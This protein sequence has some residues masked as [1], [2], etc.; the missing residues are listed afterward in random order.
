[1]SSLN[2]GEFGRVCQKEELPE[3]RVTK[4]FWTYSSQ[5]KSQNRCLQWYSFL[6]RITCEK[7]CFSCSSRV[8]ACSGGL[9]HSCIGDCKTAQHAVRSASSPDQWARLSRGNFRRSLG[10]FQFSVHGSVSGLKS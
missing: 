10:K 3:E 6:F 5:D 1:M 9:R 8:F 4:K 7:L 2:F